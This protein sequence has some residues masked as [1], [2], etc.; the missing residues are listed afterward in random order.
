MQIKTT[1]SYCIF[2]RMAKKK[3]EK[4]TC[5]DVFSGCRWGAHGN[6]PLGRS[7]GSVSYSQVLMYPVS[8]QPYSW[9]CY[10]GC[11]LHARQK[12]RARTFIVALFVNSLKKKQLATARISI[13]SRMN[14][15]KYSHTMEKRMAT[16]R[17]QESSNGYVQQHG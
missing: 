15:L 6:N 5:R 3:A 9:E 8:Q 4:P 7:F 16:E 13:S 1:R 2:T 10:Q 11:N 14:N 12:T 17:N